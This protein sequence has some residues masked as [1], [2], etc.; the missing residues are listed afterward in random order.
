ME[1]NE[2]YLEV[3]DEELQEKLRFRRRGMKSFPQNEEH[4]LPKKARQVWETIISL[5]GALWF[6][7]SLKY[8]PR[9][10]LCSAL[11]NN[12]VKDYYYFQFSSRTLCRYYL[13]SFRGGFIKLGNKVIIS[14]SILFLYETDLTARNSVT[15]LQDLGCLLYIP[16]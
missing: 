2:T 1:L 16:T 15:K 4:S 7:F 9:S 11:L 6:I 12:L 14:L 10:L 3:Y 13:L 5:K 8:F